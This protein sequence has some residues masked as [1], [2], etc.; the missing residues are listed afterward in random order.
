[1][2]ASIRISLKASERRQLA[3]QLATSRGDVRVIVD[4]IHPQKYLDA[5]TRH[6][7]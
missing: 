1:M 7:N 4:F 2:Q 3:N 5:L 6:I